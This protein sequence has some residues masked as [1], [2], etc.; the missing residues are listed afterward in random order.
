MINLVL[1]DD[2]AVFVDALQTVLTQRGF[3]VTA[4]AGTVAVLLQRVRAV[5]PDVCVVDRHFTDGDAVVRVL[6]CGATGYVHKSRGV[7]LTKR[8]R[9]FLEILVRGSG[10]SRWRAG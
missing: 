1:A 9:E 2:H 5:R 10:L 8:E 6:D 7:T 4:V 3:E